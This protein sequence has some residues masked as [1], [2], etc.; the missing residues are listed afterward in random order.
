M[1]I[2]ALLIVAA[3]RGHGACRRSRRGYAA[4]LQRRERTTRSAARFSAA[5]SVACSAATS[6]PAATRMTA[7]RLAQCSAA[8][9]ARASAADRQLPPRRL[10]ASGYGYAPGSAYN[11]NPNY[12]GPTIMTTATIRHRLAYYPYDPGYSSLSVRTTYGYDGT[13]TIHRH[14][15][16][17][18]RLTFTPTTAGPIVGMTITRG[19]TAPKRPR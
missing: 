13:G 15:R 17:P 10:P 11:P 7:R 8:W 16:S 1:R 3:A 18:R 19:R 4:Q 6:P 9:S 12:G 5:S 2:K 14:G